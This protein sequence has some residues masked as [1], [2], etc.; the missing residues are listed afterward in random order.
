MRRRPIAQRC[1][2]SRGSRR[3]GKKRRKKG[4]VVSFP[5]QVLPV[6]R[7][8]LPFKRNE[9]KGKEKKKKKGKAMSRLIAWSAFPFKLNAGGKEGGKKRRKKELSSSA[10]PLSTNDPSQG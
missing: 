9:E 8:L 5:R 4:K 3:E 7:I 10:R 2:E 6:S 1:G